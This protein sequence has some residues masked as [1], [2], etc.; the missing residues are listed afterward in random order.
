M[1][2]LGF[3]SLFLLFFHHAFAQKTQ[4]YQVVTD[5]SDIEW[6]GKKLTGEHSG[7]IGIQ[8]GALLFNGNDLAGGSL[9][10]NMQSITVTDIAKDNP[11]NKKLVNHLENKDFF[12]VA[13][14]PEAT[15]TIQSV[16]KKSKDTYD[17]KGAL[18]IKGITKPI[19]FD[20]QIT[21]RTR[22]TVVSRATLK[23]DR[24]QYGIVYKSSAL[25]E[26]TIYDVFDL[27]IKLVAVKKK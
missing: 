15:L 27:N 6:V 14:F 9:I 7:K 19:R 22:S 2:R 4:W 21:G 8:S 12:D 17:I 5:K 3:F 1:S 20:A 16:S 26:A 11:Q 13:G 10:V 23:I 18:T 25:G 24:T